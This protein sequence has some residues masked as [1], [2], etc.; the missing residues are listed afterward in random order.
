[1]HE[2]TIS[3]LGC[4]YVGLPVAQALVQRGW[5]VRGST[6]TAKKLS[7]LLDEGIEPYQI[8]LNPEPEGLGLVDFFD[9]DVLFLNFP[10]GRKRPDVEAFM[11]RAMSGLI[12][13]AKSGKVRFVVFAS[14]TSVYAGGTVRE[15]DAGCTLPD[16]ASGRALLAAES[17]IAEV[18]KFQ[19]T[20]LRYAGLYGYGRRPGRFMKDGVVR[21]GAQPVNLVH[22]DDAVNVTVSIITGNVRGEVFNVC[23]DQH[24]TRASFYTKAAKWLG[25]PAPAVVLDDT[26]PSKVVLN[27]K[28]RRTLPYS[29]EHPDP[30]QPAP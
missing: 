12:A 20:V 26:T 3:V 7:V 10:P 30:L 16:S 6:T 8:R 2:K 13:A 14:S 11:A 17:A 15:E 22:R 29:F 25:M 1:M 23:A 28:L 18:T 24:P 21:G 19:T 9:S 5:R 4:G 27:E